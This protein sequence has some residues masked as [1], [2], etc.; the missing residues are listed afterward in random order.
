MKESKNRFTMKYGSLA[1]YHRNGWHNGRFFVTFGEISYLV[2]HKENKN[3][4][5]PSLLLI[6]N[7]IE[8]VVIDK[9]VSVK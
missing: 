5:E 4:K 9:N 6:G 1:L 3:D 8:K 2:I 7:Y